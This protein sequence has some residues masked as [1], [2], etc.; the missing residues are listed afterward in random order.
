MY[1]L[2]LLVRITK[3]NIFFSFLKSPTWWFWGFYWVLHFGF[4]LGET[5]V[6]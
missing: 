5:W 4:F 1:V 2:S 6:L 3:K